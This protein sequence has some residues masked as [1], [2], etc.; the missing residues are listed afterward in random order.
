MMATEGRLR[1]F[2]RIL[3]VCEHRVMGR[4]SK[5]SPHYVND[6]LRTYMDTNGYVGPR[7]NKVACTPERG[8]LEIN[9][10]S[11][12]V[13]IRHRVAFTSVNA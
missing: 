13:V 2:L 6:F 7:K 9:F 11:T 10:R 1:M 5:T 8:T 3:Y 12:R 4:I